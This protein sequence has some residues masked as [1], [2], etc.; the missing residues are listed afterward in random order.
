M[1]RG[2]G[3][4]LSALIGEKIEVEEINQDGLSKILIAKIEANPKQPRVIFN[5]AE[6]EELMDS[7]KQNGILQPIL[8]KPTEMGKYEI[9]AGERRWRAAKMLGMEEIPA[10]IKDIADHEALEI[11]IIEN[12][13][14]ENLNPLEEAEAY[15]R[16]IE[17]H[18]YTQER[19][20]EV[21]SKSRSH[22]A[23][24]LRLLNLSDKIKQYLKDGIISLGHAKLL[25]G[26]DEADSMVDAIVNYKFNVR[27]T[28]QMIKEK[29][30]PKPINK[31]KVSYKKVAAA[32]TDDMLAIEEFIAESLRLPV[33][34]EHYSNNDGRISIHFD[35]ME[36]FDRIV[37][38]LTGSIG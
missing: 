3:R 35:G 34:I 10:I 22:I 24:L 6:L 23:N 12:I 18:Q 25:I 7:I 2:L 27:Q 13:Q 4:G 9:I 32:K 36:E 8:V 19:M 30:D 38:K 5:Q 15:Q 28:E 20:A 17:E 26:H 21:V 11:A 1:K 33:E 16:L 14:R 31:N 29:K 37:K